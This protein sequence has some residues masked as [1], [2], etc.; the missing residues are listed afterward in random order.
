MKKLKNKKTAIFWDF[1]GTLVKPHSLWSKSIYQTLIQWNPKTS[2]TYDEIRP[3]MQQGY[4]WDKPEK[5]Y[6]EFCE[7]GLWW[8][9]M[10]K[11]FQEVYEVLGIEKSAAKMLSEEVKENLL[12]IK[13]FELYED[14]K[15]ILSWS[16]ANQ[17]SNY[18]LSNNFPEVEDLT[19]KLQIWEYFDG[20]VVSAL[21]GFEKPRKELFE[22]A[23]QLAGF[24]EQCYMVGDNPYADIE[25]AIGSGM[26]AILVH[27]GNYER[28]S[29]CAE[30]LLELKD[31]ILLQQEE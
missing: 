12:N 2:I 24:P 27:K 3:Y 4:P 11:K 8:G 16:K 25:G 7:P 30:C 9:R 14:V 28:A 6:K 13:N 10:N 20:F 15:E 23:K 1:D 17:F 26:T 21:V 22:Y 18:I 31:F 29:Y 19:K 5:D